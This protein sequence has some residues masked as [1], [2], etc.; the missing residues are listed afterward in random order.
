M[1]ETRGKGALI[2]KV[3]KGE[4]L[5]IYGGL[6]GGIGMKAY[7]HD[8]L[9]AAKNL[10]LR[11]RVGD[12]D[13]PDRRKRYATNRVE[14]KVDKQNCPRGKAIESR[15]HVVAECELYQEKR[16]MLEGEMRDSNKSGMESFDVLDSREKTIAILRGRCSSQT[17]K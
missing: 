3:D 2:C 12:L 14:E 5:K 13:L 10:K 7:L 6:N 17:A 1:I 9:D 15:T 8:A 16:D 11:F 4:R